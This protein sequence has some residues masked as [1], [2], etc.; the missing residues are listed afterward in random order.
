MTRTRAAQSRSASPTT[1]SSAPRSSRSRGSTPTP[2][3]TR[4]W[5]RRVPDVGFDRPRPRALDLAAAPSRAHGVA[6]TPAARIERQLATVWSIVARVN[7]EIDATLPH[8]SCR[9]PTV[10]P[11]LNRNPPLFERW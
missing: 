4:T 10:T 3:A 5:L 8:V 9:V 1:R 11:I 6:A 2:C 7:G